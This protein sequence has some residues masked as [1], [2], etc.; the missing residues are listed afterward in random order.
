MA[1]L[2]TAL[3]R[4]ELEETPKDRIRAD[5]ILVSAR[6]MSFLIALAENA[7]SAYFAEIHHLDCPSVPPAL[8]THTRVS[9]FRIGRKKLLW[10]QK[11]RRN[12]CT[13]G[14]SFPFSSPLAE[15][16]SHIFGL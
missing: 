1:I 3:A 2:H 10:G 8:L 4:S 15:D 5:S 12:T 14:L 13:R 7:Q 6:P 16:V 11:I 9:T